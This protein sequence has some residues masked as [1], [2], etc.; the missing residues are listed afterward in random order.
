MQHTIKFKHGVSSLTAD[1]TVLGGYL[2][3]NYGQ[4]WRQCASRGAD[5]TRVNI[6]AAESDAAFES[7]CAAYVRSLVESSLA[8][9]L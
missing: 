1:F 4:G 6:I 8:P 3:I 7:Q 2:M 9:D 5:A